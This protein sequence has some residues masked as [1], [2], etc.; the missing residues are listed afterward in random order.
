MRMFLV[1]CIVN[2][3]CE[4]MGCLL[5]KDARTAMILSLAKCSCVTKSLNGKHVWAL[6][7]T[8]TA[9]NKRWT[10]FKTCPNRF[11]EAT[12]GILKHIQN[13]WTAELVAHP[14]PARD[15]RLPLKPLCQTPVCTVRM[16]S[17]VCMRVHAHLC[18][19][20]CT[21][22]CMSLGHSY[23]NVDMLIC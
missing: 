17:C 11:N 14:D 21:R 10:L 13:I 8:E 4:A 3:S 2:C 6:D 12:S 9:P 5:L 19:Y 22:A 18:V 23:Q 1:V 20:V 7:W 15:S 16:T